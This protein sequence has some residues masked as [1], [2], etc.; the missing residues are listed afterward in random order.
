MSSIE[1]ILLLEMLVVPTLPAVTR[2]GMVTVTTI[3]TFSYDI[4]VS[5]DYSVKTKGKQGHRLG[6]PSVVKVYTGNQNLLV[7][8][9][10]ND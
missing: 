4:D 9:P 8:I 3:L 6:A 1:K 2:P 10:V 7:T 5:F